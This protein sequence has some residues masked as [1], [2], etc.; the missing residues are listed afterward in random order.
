MD[1]IKKI[2][3]NGFQKLNECESD[4]INSYPE[5]KYLFLIPKENYFNKPYSYYLEPG[6][7]NK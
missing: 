4:V 2:F 5:I 3:E 6:I 1:A 7:C